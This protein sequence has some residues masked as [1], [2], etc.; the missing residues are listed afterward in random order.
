MWPSSQL[1]RSASQLG[2]TRRK[3]SNEGVSVNDPVIMAVLDR[4]DRATVSGAVE[5]LVLGA[6]LGRTDEV[7]D[8]I[9]V[10]RPVATDGEERTPV[11]AYLESVA[12]TGFRGIGPACELRLRPGPGLTLVVGRNGSGKSSFAEAA[13]FALTGDSLRWSGKSLDWKKGWR[14]LHAD[15]APEIKVTIR[16]EGEREPRAV[17]V[18]WASGKLESAKTEVTVPGQGRHSLDSLGWRAAV[19]TFR[20]F[21]SY[22]ELTTIAGGRPIDRYNALAPMLGLESL[23]APIEDLRQARLAAEKRIGAA[24]EAVD[25]ALDVL[26]GY[27]DGS[28]AE[29]AAAI[30]GSWDLSRIEALI[31]GT[32][33]A[34]AEREQLLTGL[35]HIAAPD[36]DRVAIAA[37]DLRV[38]AEGFEALRGSDA[39][40][41]R[42]L[43][44]LLESAVDLHD[45]HGDAGCPV[46]G[47]EDGLH[48]DRVAEL[49]NEIERLRSEARAVDDALTAARNARAAA[50]AA[51]GTLPEV[52][53]TA[54]TVDVGVDVSELQAAWDE[55]FDAPETDTE[56]AAHLDSACLL[57]AETTNAIRVAAG[58]RRQQ[59][60]DQW[61]PIAEHLAA[62]LPVARAGQL[63]QR[64][65]PALEKAERWLKRC[66]AAIRNERF[67][68]VKTQVTDVW[69]TLAVDSNVTL[70]DVRLGTKKVEMDV[71]V[72]GDSGAAL[73]V[74][75]Q[76]ELN[77]LALSLFVPRVTFD[78]SPFR[79]A[80]LDDPVQAMDSVRVD[81]LARVL[82][83]LAQT[84]QVVVFTHDDRLSSAIRRL[85]IPATIVSVTRRPRSQVEL[86]KSLDPIQGA[87]EDA[88]AVALSDGLPDEVRRRVVPGLCRQAIEAACL[89]SGRR[90]LLAGGMSLDECEETWAAADKLLP[91]VAIGLYA[92]PD[93][94]GDVYGTLNNKFGSWA[95]DTVRDC[96]TM[97][98]SGAGEGTDLKEL[99]SRSESLATNLAAL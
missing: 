21:L 2:E 14:N 10:E 37:S 39:D 47:R 34:S 98:H 11:R 31:A 8:G 67:D 69:D 90:R 26:S 61:R 32:A 16:V 44:E 27:S 6:L 62:M 46:C 89:E 81:G 30:S 24:H 71:T 82:H 63:A 87:I 65:L 91:R 58:S 55:W 93:R 23:R 77:A 20:P 42:K 43:A 97:T 9:R 5:N 25:A 75:S 74:M 95:A 92:D 78:D 19:K 85:Q 86:K 12:V 94:A 60:A 18:R 79:F 1:S 68:A 13:E 29:A 99:V 15:A 35:E 3:A 54:S 72:D 84:H 88:R 96:N 7:V 83:D 76:G 41:A 59:L 33:P 51:M 22:T 36:L 45:R 38:A 64:R 52:L 70:E 66:E 53:G 49:R 80:M 28:P 17:R 4:L 73:G 50:N 57:L 40:R 48:S 56:F